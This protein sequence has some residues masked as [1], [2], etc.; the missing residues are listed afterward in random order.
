MCSSR[1]KRNSAG[2]TSVQ[3]LC[4][5]SVVTARY[6]GKPGQKYKVGAPPCDDVSPYRLLRRTCLDRSPVATLCKTTV[7]ARGSHSDSSTRRRTL[8]SIGQS[9]PTD[10]IKIT[11]DPTIVFG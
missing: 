6:Y 9:I 8:K 1:M 10:D 7:R 11:A 5:R 2:S 4:K 3:P